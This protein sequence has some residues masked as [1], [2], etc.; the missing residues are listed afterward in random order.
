[1]KKMWKKMIA[2]LLVVIMIGGAAP[3][4]V[5]AE[6]ASGTCGEKVTWAF[7]TWDGTLTISGEGDMEEYDE[8]SVPWISFRDQIRTAVIQQGVTSIG[9]WSFGYCTYLTSVTI[10]NSVEKIGRFAFCWCEHLTHA[11]VPYGVVCIEMGAFA[12]CT[13][14]TSIM[15][16]ARNP[17]YYSDNCGVLYNKMNTELIQY[18]AGRSNTVFAVPDG[19]T[20]IG[21]GAFFYCTHLT[22]VKISDSVICIGVQSFAGSNH[23]KSIK[24]PNRVTQIGN[25]A[26][27]WC[28][29]LVFAH[30]PASVTEI[31]RDCFR[32]SPAYICSD[33]AGCYAE[34]YAEQNGITFI[35]CRGHET[36]SK[37]MSI[38]ISK[39][40]TKTIYTYRN[41][42]SV[43]LS[44]MEL[45]VTYS[46][47]TTQTV[48]D[49][50]AIKETGYSAKPVGTKTITVDYE[51]LT[52][53]FDVTVKYAWWQ[54][55]IR[56]FLLGF[57][58]Y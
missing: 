53:Q 5:S 42:T 15:V 28:E 14:L 10:P 26:F 21:D 48:T 2:M 51:G 58:W 17:A 6:T 39:T 1:M 56:I 45:E 49:L 47:G 35:V 9:A 3:L 27:D 54:W 46:D 12:A 23:L 29:R 57:I 13:G 24:I 30:I 43:N 33:T 22:E 37:P 7:D 52:D 50:S 16:D 11:V 19:V 31:G 8:Y 34:T 41:D 20:T 36:Q 40:P 55:L 18:P 38:H 25:Q 44:G 32:Y 4:T